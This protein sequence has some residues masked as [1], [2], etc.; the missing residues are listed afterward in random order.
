MA[1]RALFRH[2]GA[3]CFFDLFRFYLFLISG[4]SARFHPLIEQNGKPAFAVLP[5]TSF[6]RVR[7]M[8]EQQAKIKSGIPGPVVKAYAIDGK[9]LVLAWREHLG[10]SQTE[11]AGKAGM[12]QPALS[13]IEK[14]D[15]RPRTVT[16]K[17]LADAMGLKPEQVVE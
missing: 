2:A 11:V 6:E 10:L 4:Q 9:S 1:N 3:F 13:R 14:G 15:S 8:L 7:P 17:K 12:K 16:L 5:W